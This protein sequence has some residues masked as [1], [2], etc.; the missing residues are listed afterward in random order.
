MSFRISKQN[1]PIYNAPSPIP[2]SQN[3]QVLT[4]ING[5]PTFSYAGYNFSGIDMFPLNSIDTTTISGL[6]GT[7]YRQGGGCLSPDGN[8]YFGPFGTYAAEGNVRKALK[9][10]PY[11]NTI[12]YISNNGNNY[13]YG[14]MVCADNGKIFMLPWTSGTNIQIIDTF[15][16]D[17]VSYLDVSGLSSNYFGLVNFNK[18]IYGIPFN[19]SNVLRINPINLTTSTDISG[20]DA[21]GYD[22]SAN[23]EKFRGGV[24]GPDGNIYCIPSSAR[25]VLRF[26]PFTNV[27]Q[28]SSTIDVSGYQGGALASNGNIYMVP[29]TTDNIGVI[30]TSNFT[31]SKITTY[32][33]LNGT[34]ANISSIGLSSQKFYSAV[35]APNGLIYCIPEGGN[36]WLTIN[37]AT[38]TATQIASFGGSDGFA[39]AALAPNGKIYVGPLNAN[40]APII[41]TGLPTQNSWM[42]SRCFNNT[43]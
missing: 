13:G 2:G 31:V 37:P 7:S 17:A 15:N 30:D 12:S 25:R 39:G 20:I 41:K 18:F 33:T 16:N 40:Y 35:S 11:T 3:S 14:G 1:I 27:V 36:V 24:V 26:N 19:G 23:T 10:N 29:K 4:S 32:T 34:T 21:S 8:V 22:I 5:T 9:I 38:N 43:P 6:T 42:L 28:Q